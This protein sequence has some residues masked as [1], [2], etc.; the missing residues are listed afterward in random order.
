MFPKY[1]VLHLVDPSGLYGA[2][3]VI[4]NLSKEMKG[5][6]FVPIIG[7]ISQEGNKLPE[8]GKAAREL[9]IN[10]MLF[11]SRFRFDPMCVHRIYSYLSGQKINILHSHGY[12]ASL[13]AFLSNYLL[14]IPIIITSHL[15]FSKGD[16]KLKLYHALEAKI[17]KAVSAVVGVSEEICRKI[18]VK[19]VD[20]EKVYL[21]HNG[22]DLSNYRKYPRDNAIALFNE[23]NINKDDFVIGTAG[24]LDPQ[25]GYHYLLSAM[26]ILNEKNIDAKCVIFGEGPLREELERTSRE[27]DLQNIVHFPGFRGDLINF[28]DLM[29]IFVLTSIDE[30]LPMILLEAMA[31]KKTIISTPVGAIDK[32]L[33]HE[34]NA[35][36]YDVG[37]VTTL[38]KYIIDLKNNPE[39]REKMG[40]EAFNRFKSQFSSEV[41]AKKYISIYDALLSQS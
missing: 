35:F 18:M 7:I 22:I 28:L 38:A 15:W 10:T 31:M 40:E 33:T 39:R 21:I 23:L 2:E 20:H 11:P 12:K 37:D 6:A 24:R 14:K 19:G 36:L 4:L 1:K 13:L 16:T 9:G 30:G 27:L 34:Q 8:L 17:M 26:K 41:M 3:R 32:V 25:K 29:D 5:S